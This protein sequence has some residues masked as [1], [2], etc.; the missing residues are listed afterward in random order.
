VTTLNKWAQL[1]RNNCRTIFACFTNIESYFNHVMCSDKTLNH[2][3]AKLGININAQVNS[4]KKINKMNSTHN[5]QSETPERGCMAGALTPCLLKGG[6][7]G[8]RSLT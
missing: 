3:C 1:L 4:T 5:L 8:H 7:R 2:Y 6:Q